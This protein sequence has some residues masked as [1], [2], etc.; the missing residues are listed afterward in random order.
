MDYFDARLLVVDS[1]RTPW[2]FWV[3][4]G[5]LATRGGLAAHG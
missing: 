3:P 5:E 4:L 1:Q 2:D